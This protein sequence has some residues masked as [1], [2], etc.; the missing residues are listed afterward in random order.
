MVEACW[1]CSV[2]H[3]TLPVKA[4][5]RLQPQPDVSTRRTFLVCVAFF[6]DTAPWPIAPDQEVNEITRLALRDRSFSRARYLLA[7]RL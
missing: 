1:L 5:S 7:V 4:L 2:L 6:C 3:L